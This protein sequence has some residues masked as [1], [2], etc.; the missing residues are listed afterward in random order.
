MWIF[1]EVMKC[2]ILKDGKREMALKPVT[3]FSKVFCTIEAAIKIK[4]V[5]TA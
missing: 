5:H 3:G 1:N 2:K 4:E